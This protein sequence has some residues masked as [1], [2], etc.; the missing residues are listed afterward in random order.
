MSKAP[1]VRRDTCRLCGGHNLELVMHLTPTPIGDAYVS[2]KDLD[3]VQKIYPVDLFLCHSCGHSQLLDVIDPDILYRDYIYLTSDSLGL[4]E[5]FQKYAN[6]VLHY[7]NPPKGALV[8]DIGSNDGTLL[9]F[10]QSKGM[11][12]LGIDP[13]QDIAQKATESGIETLPNYFTSDLAH[14]I[15]NERGCATIVTANNVF[16]NIDNLDSLTE[17]IRDLLTPD[18]VFVF[19]VFYLADLMQNMVFDFIY[20]EHLDYHTVKPL[21]AFFYRHGMELIDIKRIPT[22]GG[23]LR[24]TVQ[25]VSGSRKVSPSIAELIALEKRLGVHSAATFRT[26][27]AKID[28]TKN[29]LLSLLHDVRAQ[30]KAIVGYGASITTTTLIYH[31]SLGNLLNFIVDDNPTRQN[32]YSPGFHIP[33]LSPNAIYKQKPDYVLILAWRY[34]EPI[35]KKHQAY[36]DQGGHF[37]VPLPKVEVIGPQCLQQ[38]SKV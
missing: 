2:Q 21:M 20:H 32:L 17:A 10:F 31:F 5:H 11:R 13:A 29:Q 9:G 22:K 1:I 26:F 3:K 4:V 37:I 36:L 38:N 25:L 7:I 15:R 6:D 23:S 35:M 12:V 16:A 14:K 27:A 24:C 18:G 33:V 8:V 28:A 30:R 34:S 19:E